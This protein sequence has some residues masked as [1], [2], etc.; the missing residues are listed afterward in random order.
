MNFFQKLGKTIAFNCKFVLAIVTFPLFLRRL[1]AQKRDNEVIIFPLAHLG[2]TI[3][4]MMYVL[5]FKCETGKKICIYC[6]ENVLN[7]IKKYSCVD[8]II[9]FKKNSLEECYVRCFS[10]FRYIGIKKENR[11][12]LIATN[13]RRSFFKGKSI[14]EVYRDRVY[15]VNLDKKELFC[16]NVVDVK[17]IPNFEKDKDKII[18]INPYSFSQKRNRRLFEK[19]VSELNLMGYIVYTNVVQKLG[20][21]AIK[22]TQA[23]DCSL[24]ELYSI[25]QQIPMFLSVRSGVID[26]MAGGK[27]NIFAI[28][29]KEV[30]MKNYYSL[31]ELTSFNDYSGRVDEFAWM[32]KKDTNWVINRIKNF[33]Q[34][35]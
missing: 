19:I 23:L 29:I 34:N 1:R 13:P 11:D 28:Y 32:G 4:A 10:I 8:R 27:G 7:I 26:Y 2:D 31:Q 21:T 12:G 25:V 9:T 24:D 3:Y 14:I 22:G 15:K 20:Q 33:L 6:C 35:K 17:T 5:Q 30:T 16:P 18:V